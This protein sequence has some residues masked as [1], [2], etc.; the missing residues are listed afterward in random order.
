MTVAAETAAL[1]LAIGEAPWWVQAP[2]TAGLLGL[3]AWLCMLVGRLRLRSARAAVA[4]HR[5]SIEQP[6]STGVTSALPPTLSRS[7]RADVLMVVTVVAA[8]VAGIFASRALGG[9]WPGIAGFL[10]ISGS[11]STLMLARHRARVRRVIAEAITLWHRSTMT[12]DKHS[13]RP[14]TRHGDATTCSRYTTT[15]HDTQA[16]PKNLSDDGA[17]LEG[18]IWSLRHPFASSADPAST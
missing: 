17:L 4:R 3:L 16:R 11:T 15:S 10:A 14:S 1:V 18:S 2:V 5:P 12:N 13:S 6:N 7:K 9:G 8:L